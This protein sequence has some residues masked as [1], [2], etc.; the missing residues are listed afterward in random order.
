MSIKQAHFLLPGTYRSSSELES[1]NLAS[2]RLR[3]AVAA[4]CFGDGGWSVGFGDS[5]VGH[6][7]VLWVGKIGAGDV[8]SRSRV[9]LEQIQR[10][11]EGGSKVIID[12]TD[13]HLGFDSPMTPFYRAAV[14]FADLL[15]TPSASMANLV[16]PYIKARVEVVEEPLEVAVQPP[17]QVLVAPPVRR[18][19]WFGHSTNV[20]YLLSCL[21]RW[22]E[23][24]PE[25]EIAV[26]S[27]S[28]GLEMVQS[29]HL[30]ASAAIKLGLAHWSVQAMSAAAAAC[31]LCIIPSDAKDPRK[32][33]ASANR[34]VTAIALGLPTA[35]DSLASYLELGEVFVD[36]RSSQ[37]GDLLRNP[38]A[39]APA[40]VSHQQPLVRRF[41]RESVGRQW[42]DCLLHTRADAAGPPERKASD[43]N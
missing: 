15:V 3:A 8:V 23:D 1:S 9:W 31:D 11:R 10:L 22:P 17:R 32:L 25:V 18:V 7:H 4:Q 43:E 38:L 41:S 37:F 14:A 21:D 40:L 19:L 39:Y 5:V 27:N 34:L 12:Y 33:G 42:N 6:P 20:P 16:G 29:H 13:H 28:S 26:L 36:I 2:I 35:A 24:S 30:R